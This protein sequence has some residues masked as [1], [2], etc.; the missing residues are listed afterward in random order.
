MSFLQSIWYAKPWYWSSIWWWNMNLWPL[1]MITRPRQ[2]VFITQLYFQVSQCITW[3]EIRKLE[4][5]KKFMSFLS[6][7]IFQFFSSFINCILYGKLKKLEFFWVFQVFLGFKTCEFQLKFKK[8]TFFK[9][10]SS[11][12]DLFSVFL[13]CFLSVIDHWAKTQLDSKFQV[14]NSHWLIFK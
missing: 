8:V 11:F 7:N 10:F 13:G 3:L 6:Q 14:E 12:S 4:K 9:V 5:A 1:A 2:E